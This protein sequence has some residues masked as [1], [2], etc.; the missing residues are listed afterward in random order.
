M[1]PA[2]NFAS[3]A[4]SAGYLTKEI[5][6]LRLGETELSF[7]YGAAGDGGDR[8]GNEASGVT[9]WPLIG[10]CMHMNDSY[11]VWAGPSCGSPSGSGI[12]LHQVATYP[13]AAEA[14]NNLPRGRAP[15]KITREGGGHVREVW[16][17]FDASLP[18]FWR[19]TPPI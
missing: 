9:H 14:M 16:P 5:L 3:P 15:I 2:R 6:S 1:H 4:L 18:G 19:D 11:H 10:S 13:T 17:A 8:Q 7:F 12:T